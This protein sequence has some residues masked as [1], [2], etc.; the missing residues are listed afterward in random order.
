MIPSL[1]SSVTNP[2]NLIEESA[3]EGWSVAD[4]L[5]EL[6]AKGSNFDK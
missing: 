4:Y 6:S 2:S 5:P 3:A 1:K